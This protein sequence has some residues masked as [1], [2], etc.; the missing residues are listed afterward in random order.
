MVRVRMNQLFSQRFQPAAGGDDLRQDFRAI[1]IFI[2]HPLHG[3]ELSD[4]LADANNRGM[5]LLLRVMMLVFWHAQIIRGN[6]GGVKKRLTKKGYGGI[7][8][9]L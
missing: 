6:R 1:P 9:S 2:Q 5:A 7:R 8:H 4:D 3:L